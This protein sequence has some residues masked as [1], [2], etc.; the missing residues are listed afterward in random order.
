MIIFEELQNEG[1][2]PGK[3]VDVAE[4]AHYFVANG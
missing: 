2:K 4:G 3:V 1:W